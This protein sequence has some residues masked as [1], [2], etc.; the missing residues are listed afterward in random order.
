MLE[1]WSGQPHLSNEQRMVYNRQRVMNAR[2]SCDDQADKVFGNMTFNKWRLCDLKSPQIHPLH[3]MKC[4]QADALET[5]ERKKYW[6]DA[7]KEDMTEEDF[8]RECDQLEYEFSMVMAD[9][10]PLVWKAI[11]HEK[12]SN[13]IYNKKCTDETTIT[14]CLTMA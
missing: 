14:E 4:M 13:R 9:V 1:T 3:L 8:N 7:V 5:L 12:K 11:F 6:L 10:D 2:V